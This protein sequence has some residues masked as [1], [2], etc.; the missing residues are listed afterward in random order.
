MP[1]TRTVLDRQHAL[2]PPCRGK[3]EH[4]SDKL[5]LN[6]RIPE[7]LIHG[8]MERGRETENLALRE[9]QLIQSKLLERHS[10][11]RNQVSYAE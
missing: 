4:K 1:L 7:V 8:G 2:N 6:L 11:A 10:Y 3:G 9:C 5:F